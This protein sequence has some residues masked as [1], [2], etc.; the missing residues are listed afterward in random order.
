[1]ADAART[2]ALLIRAA[3]AE[4][5]AHGYAGTDTNKIARRAGFAPQT[6]YRWFKDKTAIFLAVYRAWEDDE[7]LVLRDLTR[8][9]AEGPDIVEAIVAHH[10]AHRRF[11]RSLRALSVEIDA[12][13]RARAESRMRQ[14]DRIARAADGAGLSR[15]QIV[16]RLLQIERL[17]DAL[18]ENE[19]ADLAL[20][21][22]AARARL[23]DLLT[24]LRGGQGV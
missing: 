15:E 24:E 14:A 22:T 23:A 18:A 13:R 19:L 20:P 7:R 5:Q 10:R 3:M 16:V 17:A 11:R 6:F 1:M 8:A 4:F 21:E 9:G 2:D 12:V